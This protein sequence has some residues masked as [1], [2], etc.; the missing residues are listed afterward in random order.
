M[1]PAVFADPLRAGGRGETEM[2][3]VA[4]LNFRDSFRDSVPLEVKVSLFPSGAPI[5][6]MK[7]G[8]AGAARPNIVAEGGDRLEFDLVGD[9]DLLKGLPTV[10]RALNFAVR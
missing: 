8:S 7:E 3:R 9:K 6:G 10:R 2:L 5:D 4:Q 1:L